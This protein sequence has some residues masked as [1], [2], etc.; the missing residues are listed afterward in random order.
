MS[1]KLPEFG[2]IDCVEAV[3][4]ADLRGVF[5]AASRAE[6]CSTGNEFVAM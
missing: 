2:A 3:F 5:A 4:S 1:E 6:R